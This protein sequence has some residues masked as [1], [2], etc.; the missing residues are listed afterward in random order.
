MPQ[1][2]HMTLDD[3]KTVTDIADS[4]A[5]V[6]A[7]FAGGCWAFL[8]FHRER[9]GRAKID[10][11]V[12]I[13][14]LGIQDR[15]WLVHLIA[16][17]SNQGKVRHWIKEFQFTLRAI[18]A[19]AG[20]VEGDAAICN[21]VSFPNLLKRGTWLPPSWSSTFIDPGVENVY[22]HIAAIPAETSFILLDGMFRYPDS[23]SEAHH[24][25]RA[26]R[27]PPQPDHPARAG[28]ESSFFVRADTAQGS[29]D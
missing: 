4:L 9:E 16:R 25:T 7:L 2:F 23:E 24:S 5:T 21:Q 15:R 13:E 17:V 18:S 19:D 14:F 12:D 26:F 6:F 3:L 11:T 8:R 22:R 20:V 1:G 28:E 27:V 29:S 10:L